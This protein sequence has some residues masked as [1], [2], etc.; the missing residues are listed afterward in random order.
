MEACFLELEPAVTAN[1][2]ER[3]RGSP[4]ECWS[5]EGGCSCATELFNPTFLYYI[6]IPYVHFSFLT[7][8]VNPCLR[9]KGVLARSMFSYAPWWGQEC[10]VEGFWPLRG[11][12]AVKNLELLSPFL[13]LSPW[14][15]S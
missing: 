8:H 2:A 4:T 9:K 3:E 13:G 6:G 10:P 15:S 7:S 1:T 14:A 12:S 5:L 11:A